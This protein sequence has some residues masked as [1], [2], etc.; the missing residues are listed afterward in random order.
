MALSSTAIST[1]DVSNALALDANALGNLK[2]SAK[3]N[4]PEAIK[5]VAK[6][7]EAIFI[8][9]M[10]KSM[11]DATPSDGPLDSQDT[12]LY[13][14]M[15]DQQISQKLASGKG[16]GLADML[17]KQLA[18][19]AGV[20]TPSTAPVTQDAILSKS[21]YLAGSESKSIGNTAPLKDQISK[22]KN[23]AVLAAYGRVSELD[24][25][26]QDGVEVLNS[27]NGIYSSTSKFKNE[28]IHSTEEII[29]SASST[30]KDIAK[31]FTEKFSL[32]AQ[33]ASKITGLPASY[34]LGQA[35]LETGWGKKEIKDIDGV[36]S[37]NLFG[38]KA[39]AGW[40]GKVVNAMTTEFVDGVP[41]KTIQ[42]FRAYDS[43]ADSFKD[44]ARMIS[45]SPKFKG[46]MNNLGSTADYATAMV[47][48]GYAT[49]PSYANKL[50]KVIR[51][52]QSIK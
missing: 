37:F 44:F 8:N 31:Q 34:M 23:N 36:T 14:A 26:I 40:S 6:Q 16:I 24:E 2:L 12:K 1:S 32:H 39:T 48:S 45:S 30:M 46:V 42:K 50:H 51:T 7:F 25:P 19:A 38:I 18:K 3:Q 17:T 21:E 28:I 35:A 22:I 27:F 13:T 52:L 41:Q 49:D 5:G 29:S 20:P 43:Y 33:D 4:S 10:L 47:N 11:R 15:F 9:M